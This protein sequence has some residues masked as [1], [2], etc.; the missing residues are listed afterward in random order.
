MQVVH[1]QICFARIADCKV[2]DG[3][4]HSMVVVVMNG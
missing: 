4:W 1:T 3:C 2:V